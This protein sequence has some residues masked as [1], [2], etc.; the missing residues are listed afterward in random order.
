MNVT[1][2]TSVLTAARASTLTVD[3]HAAVRLGSPVSNA[4]KVASHYTIYVHMYVDV[5]SGIG[6]NKIN[7]LYT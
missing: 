6:E 5:S 3:T 1:L 4:S 2:T 7:C